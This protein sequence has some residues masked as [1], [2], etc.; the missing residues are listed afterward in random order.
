M[1]F[2]FRD[3]KLRNDSHSEGPSLSPRDCEW[4]AP[5]WTGSEPARSRAA[6]SS[7][8]KPLPLPWPKWMSRH[9]QQPD[10]DHHHNVQ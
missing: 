10:R 4:P 6:A 9:H 5:G 2:L 8:P 3:K 1:L 7:S